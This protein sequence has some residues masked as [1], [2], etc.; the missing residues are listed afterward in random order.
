MSKTETSIIKHVYFAALFVAIG[1]A[2]DGWL[3]PFSSLSWAFV[4]SISI[5]LTKK[6]A[7]V[8]C[9]EVVLTSQQPPSELKI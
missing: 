6:T 2:T 1:A 7:K 9:D 3:P 8:N 5:R 4:F